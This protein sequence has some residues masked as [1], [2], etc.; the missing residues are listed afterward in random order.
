MA[1]DIYYSEQLASEMNFSD[2]GIGPYLRSLSMWQYRNKSFD[3]SLKEGFS[4][5]EFI[6][7]KPTGPDTSSI[8]QMGT[9]E[10]LVSPELTEKWGFGLDK[11]DYDELENHYKYLKSANPRADSTQEIYIRDCCY[12]KTAQL[13]AYR[14]SRMDDYMKLTESY[15]K[16]YKAGG[17]KA[18]GDQTVTEDFTI[19]VTAKTIEQYTPAEYYKDKKLYKDYDG[20]EEY[21]SRHV[22][23]PLK[24]IVLG[25]RDKDDKYYV[26]SED[27][28]NELDEE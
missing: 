16:S 24:N 11:E 5:S 19:G 15:N 1:L 21:F 27:D 14:E 8:V 28:D 9:D 4:F 17:L 10:D 2:K 18:P 6:L 23:R 3:N 25:T 26:K 20:I 7:E 12:T 22:I 13:K